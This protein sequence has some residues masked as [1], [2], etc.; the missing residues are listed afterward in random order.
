M[1]AI[2]NGTAKPRTSI[3]METHDSAPEVRE[4]LS[5]LVER[6]TFHN[7]D[8]GFCVLR[9][10][11]RGHRD[12]VTVLG[13]APSVSVGEYI[14]ASGR[15]ENHRDHGQQFRATFLRVTP[16][17]STEGMERY[18]GSGLI[19][20]IGPTFASRLVVAFG[21]A[22]FDIIE[23]EPQKLLEV[24]GIGPKRAARITTSW[25]EQKV[26]REIVAFL[27][28]HGVSTS[29]A[30][31][32]YKT[33]GPDAI[34]LVSENPYRL[35]RDIVGIGFKSADLIAQRLG[36]AKTAMIRAKAGIVYALIEAVADGH[37]G[38]SEDQLL[39]SAEM[40][41]EIPKET[42]ADAL[43]QEVREG[44]L[45]ADV[46]DDQRVVFL[47]HL[48]R[49]ER[50]IAQRL[51]ELSK[52][53]PPWPAIDAERAM[54]WVEKKLDVVLAPSQRVAISLALAN[55]VLVV[56]GGPGVGKTTL[57]N[58]ILRILRAKSVAVALCAPTG[59]AAK[60]LAESTGLPARTIHRLLEADPRSGGFKRCEANPLECE[61][62]V[63][64]EASMVDVPLM[65]SLIRAIPPRSALLLVGD[66]D[67]LPS[68][69]P[70]QVLA[71]IIVSGA[72][73]VARLTEIFRQA[74][75]SRIVVNAHRINHGQMP[76]TDVPANESSDFYFVEAP[77]PDDAARKVVEIVSS[78]IP[79][80]F[81][82]D[83]IRDVQVL[84]PMNRGRLGARSLNVALQTALNG[85]EARPTV[86]RFGW[87]F[88]VGDKIMQ[89]VNDYGKDVFNGDA[90][91]IQDI[92]T[93]AQEVMVDF[94]GRLVAY[95]FGELD[96]VMPAY[97]T[98]IHKS[99][100]S[101]YAAVVIPLS[102]QHYVMLRRNLVYTAITRG[103]ELVVL[104]G[105]RKALRIAVNDF[106]SERR[107]SKLNRWLSET[108]G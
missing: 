53:P 72:V 97:A 12:L 1:S 94:D 45:V 69:G 25:A 62:L 103:K 9:V 60:R 63:V 13:D 66:A 20:G 76:E 90:G 70:G 10:K 64:D 8:N 108:V 3:R 37:C 77:D 73:A 28:S 50:L 68:V 80:R 79:R 96:E 95:D 84:C 48:W 6:V 46:V 26:I 18:L 30:V 91:F 107:W 75:Q 2:A 65:A 16:P 89:I 33:Y 35:A 5:G 101:E 29:R 42:L 105:Q 85:D 11:V 57:V 32:I 21:E 49:A 82:L 19:K 22:V 27:Q 40:L 36:I 86:V 7:S 102:T 71:D 58:S 88:R 43:I 52:E 47:A 78:R 98:S 41:L 4:P 31:R 61:L 67:Q 39:T 81:G 38:L 14:Q 17:T 34:P 59:R 55:K 44:S 99:Q 100:G 54:A 23:G 92:D 106:R 87:S 74:A 93:D 83:P 24:E 15:W 56:T 51:R 104:V